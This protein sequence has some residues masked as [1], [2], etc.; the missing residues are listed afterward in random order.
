MN[1]NITAI[2]IFLALML[3][4]FNSEEVAEENATVS[5]GDVVKFGTYEQD[6]DL[7]NGPEPVKWTVLEIR[8]EK[9]LILSI[10]G[11][12]AMPYN[13][14]PSSYGESVE[15]KNCSLRS[16]LNTYF[17][18]VCFSEDEKKKIVCSSDVAL[19][20]K[21]SEEEQIKSSD[22]DYI[23]ILSVEEAKRYTNKNIRCCEATVYAKSHQLWIGSD[24]NCWW[25]LRTPG[26]Q[27]DYVAHVGTE[28]DFH[29]YGNRATT[30]DGAVRPALWITLE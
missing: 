27:H 20:Q 2:A 1:K 19:M 10:F 18:A 30:K 6:G 13:D 25:W 11:L 4:S 22:G 17:F 14:N 7:G 8:K 12:D 28:G 29:I 23:F 26:E 15:W 5:V 24:G 16:W 9:A 21:L 3:V